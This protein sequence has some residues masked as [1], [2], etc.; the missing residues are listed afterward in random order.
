MGPVCVC[1]RT[2]WGESGGVV[3]WE[4]EAIRRQRPERWKIA[5]WKEQLGDKWGSKT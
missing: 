4:R 1:E 5:R 2:R 3:K